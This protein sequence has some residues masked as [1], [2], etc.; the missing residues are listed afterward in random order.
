VSMSRERPTYSALLMQPFTEL[1]R[2]HEELGALIETLHSISGERI[3]VAIAHRTLEAAIL[4]TKDPDLGLRAARR[5]VLGDAGTLDFVVSSAP[6]VR[7]AL[8]QASRYMRLLNDCLQ[9]RLEIEG[10]AALVRLDQRMAS[11]R[12]ATDFLMGGFFCNH[13]RHWFRDR[14]PE[15][16]VLFKHA[17]PRDLS[18]YERTFAPAVLRFNAPAFAFRFDRLHLDR[19]L[20][21]ASANLHKVLVSHAVQA[22][23]RLPVAGSMTMDVRRLVARDL[24][25]GGPEI[26]DVATQLGMGIRTLGRR[27]ESEGTTFRDLVDDVRRELALEYLG[28]RDIEL[29][30][31]AG[32]LGF[33]HTA[34]FHRAFRRWTGQTPLGYR[35]AFGR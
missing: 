7:D 26:A 30:E 14:L 22:L 24:S 5:L 20:Q 19:P 16:T 15:L 34:T 27:L 8:E 29:V 33:S 23:E 13:F 9:V 12:A 25:F 18:E 4:Y 31:I 11:P 1:F 35:R 10:S 2:A 3:L 21:G 28:R 17:A 6:T 32:R